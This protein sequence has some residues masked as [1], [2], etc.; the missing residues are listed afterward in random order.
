MFFCTRLNCDCL[1]VIWARSEMMP[2]LKSMTCLIR[3][4]GMVLFGNGICVD[5]NMVLF[6]KLYVSTFWKK[7]IS[8]ESPKKTCP[9]QFW[10][11]VTG[12]AEP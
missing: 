7:M 10:L 4:N 5:V 3:G 8:D 11:K 1:E 9:W 2:S 6:W 12:F